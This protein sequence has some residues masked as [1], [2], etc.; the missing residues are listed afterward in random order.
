MH[1][2]TVTS[3][4]SADARA[5]LPSAIRALAP[6]LNDPSVLS[7]AAGVP[8]A[9]TFPARALGEAAER[10]LASMPARALQYDVTRGFLPLRERIAERTARRGLSGDATDTILTTGSQQGLDL[11][12]R[13]LLDPG[14]VVLVEV[15]TY[16]GAL[17]T[18]A[19]RR[20]RPVGVRR[21]EDGLDLE[22]LT[23]VVTRLRAEGSIVKALYTIPNFQNPSGLSMNGPAKDRLALAAEELSLFVLEDD[24]YGELS[25]GD[26]GAYDAT[27]LASRSP[28]SVA[29]LGSFSKTLA[30]GFRVGWIQGP[31]VLLARLELGKQSMDLC[32]STFT[33]AIL[34]SYLA[35]EDYDA[36][37]D[38]LRDFYRGRKETLLGAMA[39]H[40]PPSLS[41]TDPKGGLFTWVTL[42]EGLDARTLLP[43]CVAETRTA[44]VP[45]ESFVVE[46]DG[47]R[48]LRMT[49]AKE[50]PPNL[51]E[52]ARRLGAFF[53]GEIG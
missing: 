25:F 8:N 18:F 21:N 22:H 2:G 7:F 47:R 14:D 15:P 36:H 19:A 12:S 28:S 46:G 40:F 13:V 5:F 9:E 24:P 29:Y 45:G 4:F 23:E 30:A 49:F 33:A 38:G 20:A 11:L 52:G 44:Y 39:A 17:A 3:L 42:P 35:H 27:P 6:L 51:V 31:P 26:A 1:D 37:I 41:W 53:R 43:K 32:S 34:E 50:S 10:V 16:V 48:F